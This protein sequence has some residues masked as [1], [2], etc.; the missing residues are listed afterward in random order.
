MIG[1]FTVK[2]VPGNFHLSSHGYDGLFL[3]TNVILRKKMD[4]SHIIHELSF[5]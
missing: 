4:T 5:G 3:R 1:S 2:A